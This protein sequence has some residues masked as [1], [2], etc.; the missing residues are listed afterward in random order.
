MLRAS[1]N[2]LYSALSR[3]RA[4]DRIERFDSGPLWVLAPGTHRAKTW[5]KR[6]GSELSAGPCNHESMPMSWQKAAHTRNVL[7]AALAIRNNAGSDRILRNA[8]ITAES[9]PFLSGAR[10]AKKTTVLSPLSIVKQERR[11]RDH[12]C[13]VFYVVQDSFA[14]EPTCVKR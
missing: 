10:A 6:I 3:I 14:I 4:R 11:V 13:L 5:M 1:G 12:V 9:M 2:S 8:D 7:S